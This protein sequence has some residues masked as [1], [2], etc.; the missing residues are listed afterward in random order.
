MPQEVIGRTAW[1]FMVPEDVATL[2]LRALE[3][4]QKGLG[5]SDVVNRNLHRDGHEMV[6]LT[7]CVPLFDASGTLTGFRGVNKD[8]TAA[9]RAEE[10]L[11]RSV[12]ELNTLWRISETV[13][14]PRD[15]SAAVSAVMQEISDLFRA[16]LAMAV[17][18]GQ[19]VDGRQVIAADP[20]ES[21]QYSALFDKGSIAHYTLFSDI[22]RGG[23]PG[24]D[25]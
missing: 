25:Q 9:T 15:L 8:I 2:R 1:D 5:C 18:F 16:R 6:L 11:R 22:A 20:A 7:S 17:I 13:A 12:T 19:G 21:A 24:S 10:S 4:A 3:D 14:G 23:D